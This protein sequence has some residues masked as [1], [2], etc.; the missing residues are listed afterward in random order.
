[1]LTC[2]FSC[3]VYNMGGENCA[4]PHCTANRSVHKQLSYHRVPKKGVSSKKGE[5]RE[6][7]LHRINRE[8]QWFVNERK[9]LDANIF[10]CSRHFKPECFSVGKFQ[11]YFS[12]FFFSLSV[13]HQTN[14][15]CQQFSSAGP[16]LI[17]LVPLMSWQFQD[18]I[19][20]P[21]SLSEE[22]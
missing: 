2:Y 14:I 11:L 15:S 13:H 21:T 4:V 3:V 1:M 9:K 12:F 19:E 6:K 17:S 5:W 10:I 22:V 18:V 16:V 8:D 7:L 20:T